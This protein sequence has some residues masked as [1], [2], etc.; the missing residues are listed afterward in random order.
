MGRVYVIN[1][2][3]LLLAID[4][5][6]I[7]ILLDSGDMDSKKREQSLKQIKEDDSYTVIL[8]SILAGGVGEYPTRMF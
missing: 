7:Q 8:V 4:R 3:F 2:G 6:E 1:Q 5:S